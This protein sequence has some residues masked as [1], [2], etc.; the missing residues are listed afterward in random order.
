[1]KIGV[2]LS[3]ELLAFADGEAERRGLSRSGLLAELLRAAQIHEQTRTYIDRHGWD[4]AED[5][6]AW[7]D[8]QAK[9]TAREYGDDEW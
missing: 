2:S 6:S 5:E 9:R 1:M 8:Y 7:H 3:D 4:V